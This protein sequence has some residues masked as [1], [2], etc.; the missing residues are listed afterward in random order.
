MPN[1]H[2]NAR[3][4][5]IPWMVS[6]DIIGTTPL[7]PGCN[8]GLTQ[9]T[10]LVWML[11]HTLCHHSQPSTWTGMFRARLLKYHKCNMGGYISLPVNTQ[12]GA[13][14]K[15]P[16]LLLLNISKVAKAPMRAWRTPMVSLQIMVMD[17]VRMVMINIGMVMV[18][19]RMS[20]DINVIKIISIRIRCRFGIRLEILNQVWQLIWAARK[21]VY[22]VSSRLHLMYA[23][24]YLALT[25]CHACW[26]DRVPSSE[27]WLAVHI[28]WAVDNHLIQF[29]ALSSCETRC[30]LQHL[31]SEQSYVSFVPFDTCTV[32]AWHDVSDYDRNRSDQHYCTLLPLPS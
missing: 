10:V 16:V 20:N 7:L 22:Q 27:K 28:L 3:K 30:T 19:V 13:S 25:T 5:D 14:L 26:V 29:F 6:K 4:V 12:I 23:L 1:Y 2:A 17:K 32:A 11:K 21:N 24:H 15:S 9:T 31:F 8:F 18:K